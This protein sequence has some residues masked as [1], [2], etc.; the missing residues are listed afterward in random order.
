MP[1]ALP[2]ALLAAFHRTAYRVDDGPHRFVIRIGEPAPRVDALLEDHQFASAAYLTAANP[3]AKPLAA[4]ENA[5]RNAALRHHAE[6]TGARVLV[7]EGCAEDG[8]WAEPSFLVLGLSR[9]QAD[10]L[11]DRFEQAAYVLLEHGR[12]PELVLRR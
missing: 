1:T 8:T 5:H 12:P 9:A 10:A 3:L 6:A 2:P 11:A 7:G 4:A